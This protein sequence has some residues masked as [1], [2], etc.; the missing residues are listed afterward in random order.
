VN[1]SNQPPS[2]LS[3]AP[4]ALSPLRTFLAEHPVFQ[5]EEET[6]EGAALMKRGK[7][8]LADLEAERDGLVRPLNAKVKATNEEYREARRPLETAVEALQSRVGLWMR[9]EQ[10]RREREAEA[11]QR[12]AVAAA[13]QWKV[14]SEAAQAAQEDAAMGELG[15]DPV[16]LEEAVEEAEAKAQRLLRDAARAERDAHVR[17]GVGYGNA[18]TLKEKE[19][20]VIVNWHEAITNLGCTERIREA[21]L[22]EAR[23][24]RKNTGDLPGGVVAS[25]TREI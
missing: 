11:V 18:V 17:L 14:L 7:A 25:F 6:R 16:A 19:T 12:A 13:D 20:L 3:L 8:A 2:W 1:I 9:R 22:T 23:S 5:S 10:D 21:I 4:E 24:H 15:I